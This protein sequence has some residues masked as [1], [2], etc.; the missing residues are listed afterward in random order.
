MPFKSKVFSIKEVN[1][2]LLLLGGGSCRKIGLC[3]NNTV[4]LELHDI[5][6]QQFQGRFIAW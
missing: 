3:V 6:V 4:Q 5:F 2:M 1:Y